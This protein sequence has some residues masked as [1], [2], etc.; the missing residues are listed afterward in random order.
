MSL[1]PPGASQMEVG[2]EVVRC[3]FVKDPSGC[4]IQNE[5]HAVWREEAKAK[6]GIVIQAVEGA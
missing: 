6:S 4:P 2:E 5:R 1:V 3:V